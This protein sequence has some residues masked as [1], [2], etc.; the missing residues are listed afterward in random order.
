MECSLIIMFAYALFQAFI[1]TL[2]SV[3]L[4]LPTAYFFYRYA[5]FG[6]QFFLAMALVMSIMPTQL[7]ACAELQF[8]G[9]AGFFGIIIAHVLLNM[10]FA[11]YVLY[12]ACYG[13]NPAW[14][15]VAREYGATEWRIFKDVFLPFLMPTIASLGAII[16][17]LCFTSSSLPHILGTQGYH[18][19]PD[20]AIAHLYNAGQYSLAGVLYGMR[21]IVVLLLCGNWYSHASIGWSRMN[22]PRFAPSYCTLRQGLG[23]PLFL[24]VVGAGLIGPFVVLILGMGNMHVV[25]FLLSLFAGSHD[26]VLGVPIYY[27]L[28]NSFLLA[29][30]SSVVA[31]VSG[32]IISVFLQQAVPVVQRCIG[33]AHSSVFI[34]GSVGL[35]ILFVTI[36]R[37]S[38]M[39]HFIVAVMC[40]V[41]LNLPFVCRIFSAQLAQWHRDLDLTAQAYGASKTA[42][43][44][45]LKAV[46]L[47]PAMVQAFCIAF[48]LSLTEVGAG[49]VFDGITGI[50]LPMAIKVYRAHG[51]HAGVSGLSLMI[52]F[53]VFCIGCVVQKKGRM[54]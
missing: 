25:Y 8:Y 50:T 30:A 51:L 52:L 9:V 47:K 36:A 18:M 54:G 5:F 17:V 24:S 20:C 14:C 7:V 26:L 46:W 48:G 37:Q 42:R 33:I 27:P 15:F 34:I 53:V 45:E 19:T 23:W 1:S 11:L 43:F 22:M 35:G 44:L 49:S 31:V 28:I 40:H 41:V 39:N 4:A 10:P 6:K 29:L 3:S 16:F 32:L 12:G 2:V 13:L 38:S 21:L